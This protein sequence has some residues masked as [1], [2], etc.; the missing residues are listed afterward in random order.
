MLSPPP[1]CSFCI[2]T[3]VCV[4]VFCCA[5]DEMV[6]KTAIL[7]ERYAPNLRWYVDTMLQLIGVAG[8]FISDDIWHRAVRIVTNNE[9]LQAYAARK[10]YRCE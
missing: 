6:L 1:V 8:E 5:Q 3:A 2:G 10:M 4:Y 9:D 7:A